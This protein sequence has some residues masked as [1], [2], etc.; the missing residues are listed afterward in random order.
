M[1][2]RSILARSPSSL[3]DPR[4]VWNATRI[5][6]SP[7]SLRRRDSTGPYPQSAS[8]YKK[9]SCRARGGES[10]PQWKLSETRVAWPIVSPLEAFREHLL[11][12]GLSYGNTE[13]S[14]LLD[15]SNH[16]YRP[17]DRQ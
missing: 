10:G 3:L 8:Q 7:K 1:A 5:L 14:W 4:K 9:Q 11:G 6:L 2:V 16:R 12:S 13:G 15:H 17:A